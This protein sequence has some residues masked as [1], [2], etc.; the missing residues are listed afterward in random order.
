MAYTLPFHQVDV[1][2]AVP[3]K[4]NPVAVVN[5]LDA[6]VHL[7]DEA[8]IQFAN[9]TNLSETTFLLPPLNASTADYRLR[10][11]TTH[12][13]LPFAGHPTIGSCKAFLAAGGKP[14]KAG[15]VTQECG[16]GLIDLRLDEDGTISFLAP[17]LR[18]TGRV[19]EKRI[20]EACKAMQIDSSS[21]LSAEWI[22]NGPEWFAL[23]LTNAQAVLDVNVK[24][25][26]HIKGQELL[27]GIWGEYAPGGGP[28][29]AKVEVRTFVESG[30]CEDP[31][32]GSFAAG[33]ATW[34]HT[35][36]SNKDRGS[37]FTISQGTKL[38][39]QGRIQV[40]HQ[41]QDEIW[42]GG[43]ATVCISGTVSF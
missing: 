32:T 3:Y 33:L 20:Q 16:L 5:A 15:Q 23:Q 43:Q 27:W 4:G 42:I 35:L 28:D 2:T 7:T 22:V 6:S 11:F 8:M 40:Q 30:Q 14:R 26:E 17:S 25:L 37:N 39:R 9:W 36:A 18:K 41:G 24:A 34:Q 21:I 19:D 38:K 31:V 29:G 13:E 10:I 1:F 12:N